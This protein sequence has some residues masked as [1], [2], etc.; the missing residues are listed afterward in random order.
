MDEGT[1][2]P[3]PRIT[4]LPQVSAGPEA[5]HKAVPDSLRAKGVKGGCLG[6]PPV[7][8]MPDPP[9]CPPRLPV[10]AATR[11]ESNLRVSVL[12]CPASRRNVELRARRQSGN[13]QRV[14]S[15][16]SPAT[17][18]A[19]QLRLQGN[20]TFQSLVLRQCAATDHR[21]PDFLRAKRASALSY[22]QGR[23][24][25]AFRIIIHSRSKGSS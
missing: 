19:F 6:Q 17:G 2:R 20:V 18:C 22:L 16:V 13:P 25:A 4:R 24:S 5:R 1:G 11:R 7:R 21:L 15:S 9:G 8:S 23:R 3:Q 14:S 12:A 10:R